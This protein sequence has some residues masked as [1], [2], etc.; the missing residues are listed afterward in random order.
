MS[1]NEL[2]V[3]DTENLWVYNFA[4]SQTEAENTLIRAIESNKEDITTWESHCKNY[5]DAER[6]KTYLTQAKNKKYEIMTYD[7]YLQLEK[8]HYINQPLTEITERPAHLAAT[9]QA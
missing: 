9:P 1:N 8:T 2:C 3:V 5:P 6:F 4:N 7:K